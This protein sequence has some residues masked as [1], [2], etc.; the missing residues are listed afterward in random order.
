MRQKLATEILWRHVAPDARFEHTNKI[1]A[2][3]L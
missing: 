2:V 3:L 1:I